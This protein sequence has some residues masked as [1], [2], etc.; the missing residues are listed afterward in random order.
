MSQ[1]PEDDVDDF[2]PMEVYTME[3]FMEEDTILDAIFEEILE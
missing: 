1:Q 3:D 2:D